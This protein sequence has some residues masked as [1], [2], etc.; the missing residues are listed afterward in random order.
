M[1]DLQED[2][3]DQERASNNAR[4]RI[5]N[6]PCACCSKPA[7]RNCGRCRNVKYCDNECQKADWG[8]HKYMCGPELDMRPTLTHHRAIL[9]PET[10]DPPTLVWIDTCNEDFIEQDYSMVLTEELQQLMRS[11]RADPVKSND[12]FTSSLAYLSGD[13]LKTLAKIDG[14]YPKI[15]GL[16]GDG[17]VGYFDTAAL[18]GGVRGGD[19]H[20]DHS[21]NVGYRDS[22][23]TDGVSKPNRVLDTLGKGKVKEFWKGP[24]V[25]YGM[26]KS[27]ERPTCVDLRACDLGLAVRELARLAKRYMK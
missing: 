13:G 18:V 1:A 27:A 24:L 21:I 2:I 3:S 25:I 19:E 8:C 26:A 7:T 10:S 23:T 16:L 5:D 6:T 22:L 14:T 12:P 17:L 4:E 11:T 15:A 20:L 9:L